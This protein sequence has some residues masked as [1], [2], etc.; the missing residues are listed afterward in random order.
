[1]DRDLLQSLVEDSHCILHFE[2]DSKVIAGIQ[3]AD[4]AAH[5]C[6]IM[7]KDSLG[8]V[9]KM[10]KVGENSGYNPEMMIELGFLMFASIRYCF[11]GKARPYDD[12]RPQTEWAQIDLSNYGLVVGADLRD[13]IR[14]GALDR[15]SSIYLGC[16]H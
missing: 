9:T 2:Q 16:I 10:V 5:T 13:D 15:F 3:L 1:M 4:L 11:L 12:T 14:K 7:M 6:S 8:L